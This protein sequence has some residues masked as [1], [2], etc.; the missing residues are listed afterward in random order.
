MIK[1]FIIK[2]NTSVIYT[3]KSFGK[4]VI[5]SV[6]ITSISCIITMVYEFVLKEYIF[7]CM[8]NKCRCQK[9]L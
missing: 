3:A 8:K 5:V 4:P 6:S 7:S 1:K 9:L 2:F